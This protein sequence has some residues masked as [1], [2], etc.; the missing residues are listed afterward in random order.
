MSAFASCSSMSPP[1]R[2]VSITSHIKESD[3][4]L[5]SSPTPASVLVA[6]SQWLGA[7]NPAAQ[8]Q[9]DENDTAAGSRS[10][11][12]SKSNETADGVESRAHSASV[13]GL[14]EENLV[15]IDMKILE[16][17]IWKDLPHLMVDLSHSSDVER[18]MVHY[19]RKGN[20]GIRYRSAFDGCRR[21]LHH[22]YRQRNEYD[23]VD[24]RQ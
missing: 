6:S 14:S 2:Q 17:G 13:Q 24:S 1:R 19:L 10:A 15:R 21:M 23:T 16:R 12:T 4:S 18:M 5:C 20:T 3:L 22:N 11:S 8:Q 7:A 9:L